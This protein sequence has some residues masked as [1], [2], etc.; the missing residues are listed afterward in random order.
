MSLMLG[1]PSFNHLA[2]LISTLCISL[3]W[4]FIYTTVLCVCGTPSIT[5][6]PLS[7]LNS[8]LVTS[9]SS[10]SMAITSTISWSITAGCSDL[11]Y[12]AL[13]ILVLFAVITRGKV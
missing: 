7:T 9:N 12:N 4:L 11:S 8:F 1:I 10:Y 2:I 13:A 6:G 3:V 5:S